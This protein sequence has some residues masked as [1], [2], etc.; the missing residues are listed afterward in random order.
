MP[1]TIAQLDTQRPFK[2]VAPTSIYPVPQALRE[3][4][5]LQSLLPM[6]KKSV[7]HV[8]G[9]LT[10]IKPYRFIPICLILYQ[11]LASLLPT[12]TLFG[13]AVHLPL[14]FLTKFTSLNAE[15]SACAVVRLAVPEAS[16]GT[17]A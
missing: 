7:G 13:L 6:F 5:S 11:A 3:A 8:S 4:W 12:A 16:C 10:T 9:T 17:E 15:V 14:P 1:A 2:P